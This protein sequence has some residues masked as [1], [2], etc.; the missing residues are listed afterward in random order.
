VPYSLAPSAIL[1]S[2]ARLKETTALHGNPVRT[3]NDGDTQIGWSFE[4]GDVIAPGY[5]AWNCLGRGERCETWLAW[6][7]ERFAPA[8]VK[9]LVPSDVGD[10]AS[11]SALRREAQILAR[12]SHPFLPRLYED[13][14]DTDL[15]HLVLE[16]A[17]GPPLSTMIGTKGPFSPTD[18]ATLGLQILMALHHLHA[19][20]FA[21]LD[22]KP[23][24]VVFRDGRIV[25]ID[26]GL[27]RPLGSPAPSGQAWGTEGYMA[28]EQAD[29]QPTSVAGDIYG[30][31]ATL[32]TLVTN[33]TPPVAGSPMRWRPT[34]RV[35]DRLKT[36]I[37]ELCAVDPADRP[38][39]A[40]AAMS[41][42][43]TVRPGLEP[44]WPP[45]TN[46]GEASASV[47]PR[48]R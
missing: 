9:L 16:Y 14:T 23:G 7:S 32:A 15:P 42:L 4:P 21:H 44:P 28:P 30:V 40:R 31:G 8:V 48:I 34:S 3:N 45:F 47:A 35:G 33:R 6:S 38:C 10:A 13:S 29:K 41:V 24:N 46:L 12:M 1:R 20:G 19:L 25:L 17:E 37:T 27:A 18:A 11:V 39:D 36:A 26:L 5:Q 2:L 43:R 22:V